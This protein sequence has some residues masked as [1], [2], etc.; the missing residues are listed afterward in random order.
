MWNF[1]K[2][3]KFSYWFNFDYLDMLFHSYGQDKEHKNNETIVAY[4]KVWTE[5]YPG[6]FYL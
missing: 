2:L 5:L 3:Q 1:E 4:R 6:W